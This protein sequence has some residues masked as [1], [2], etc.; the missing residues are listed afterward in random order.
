MSASS[1]TIKM[2]CAIDLAQPRSRGDARTHARHGL[3]REDQLHRGAAAG[4]VV[5]YQ[6]AGMVLHDFLDDRE[7]ETRPLRA[8]GDIGLGQAMAL[9]LGQAASIALDHD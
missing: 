9:A 6:I 8:R 2:S 1:S 3:R 4:A 7:A 5:Q